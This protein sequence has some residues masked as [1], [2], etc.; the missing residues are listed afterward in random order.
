MR[1]EF[2]KKFLKL[3]KKHP[4]RKQFLFLVKHRKDVYS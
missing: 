3:V 2:D 4:K 1:I